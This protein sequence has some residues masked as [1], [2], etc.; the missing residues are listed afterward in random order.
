MGFHKLKTIVLVF[1]M[2]LSTFAKGQTYLRLSLGSVINRPSH[3]HETLMGFSSLE[4]NPA[5]IVPKYGVA[6]SHQIDRFVSFR[7]GVEYE[8]CS[9]DGTWSNLSTGLWR[10]T[11]NDTLFYLVGL[12][13]KYEFKEFSIPL[14]LQLYPV[15]KRGLFVS[16]GVKAL[17]VAEFTTT[18]SSQLVAPEHYDAYLEDPQSVE[19][20]HS[21]AITHQYDQII[22]HDLLANY[23]VGWEYQRASSLVSIHLTHEVGSNDLF[24]PNFHILGNRHK[25]SVSISYSLRL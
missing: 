19:L 16:A 8:K 23:G 13:S 3:L 18:A 24:A 4:Y 5:P 11:Y 7:F 6:V 25:T 21:E 12:D 9:Y 22:R 17:W 14:T 20:R 15:K 1:L 2:S 10:I